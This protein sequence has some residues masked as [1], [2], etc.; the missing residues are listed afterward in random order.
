MRGPRHFRHWTPL[1]RAR[2]TPTR[3]SARLSRVRGPPTRHT[4]PRSV[5]VSGIAVEAARRGAP[6][7]LNQA[8]RSLPWFEII[9]LLSPRTKTPPSSQ[10]T[11]DVARAVF[12]R[13]TAPEGFSRAEHPATIRCR[14]SRH[15]LSLPLAP[16]FKRCPAPHWRLSRSS[17]RR[18]MLQAGEQQPSDDPRPPTEEQASWR[19]V[20][21]PL[22][23]TP[24]DR[25]VTTGR[26]KSRAAGRLSR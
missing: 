8:A 1:S 16:S 22:L 24:S 11:E 23:R 9:T 20:G 15:L 7:E 4:A 10:K 18:E 17:R 2:G 21:N 3:H 12:R 14:Q 13:C 19:E 6:R 5:L 26:S 25:F